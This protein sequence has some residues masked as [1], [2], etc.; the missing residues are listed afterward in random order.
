MAPVNRVTD[1][2][3]LHLVIGQIGLAAGNDAYMPFYHQTRDA[4]AVDLGRHPHGSAG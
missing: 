1:K 4:L 3:F 2:G